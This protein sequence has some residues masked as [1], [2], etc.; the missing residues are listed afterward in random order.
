MQTLSR[1]TVVLL[2]LL[3]VGCD[4]GSGDSLPS[5][6][7]I[8]D[9]RAVSG[10]LTY[11]GEVFL[12]HPEGDRVVVEGSGDSTARILGTDVTTDYDIFGFRDG[13]DIEMEWETE[14]GATWEADVRRRNDDEL[15]G[16]LTFPDGSVFSLSLTK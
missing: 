8:Y 5:V 2:V 11:R 16:T 6:A 15:Q 7:G 1:L 10:S 9:M 14:R 3:L 12:R 13:D 4:S